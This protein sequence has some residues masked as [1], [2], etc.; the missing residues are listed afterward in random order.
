MTLTAYDRQVYAEHLERFLPDVIVDAHTHIWQPGTLREEAQDNRAC[1]SWPLMVAP[2]CTIE[3]LMEAYA[4][5][6]PGKKVYPAL[7]GYPTAV[8]EKTNAY[9]LA[10]AKR[11]HL[12]ALFCTSYQT[13]PEAIR[14]ALTED[15]FCGIKPYQNNS[16]PYIPENEIRIYDF[17][18]P[19]HLEVMNELKGVVML[20]ISRPGRLKDPVNLAQLLEIEEHYP[21]I[22]LIVAHIG[23]AYACEDLGN[24]FDLLRHTKNMVFD[25][26]ANTLDAAMQACLEAVGPRRL[27]FGSDM[28]IT[29]MRMRRTVENGVYYNIVPRG[30]YGDVSADRHMRETDEETLTTFMYEEL[31]AFK[32]CAERLG[33][34]R[35]EIKDIL[36]R[37]AAH[38]YGMSSLT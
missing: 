20:H 36:C 29:S 13:P 16:A 18:P 15:G 10:S 30:L 22:K 9:A 34:G 6:F 27:L 7:M 32:R 1:V 37:N 26:S 8:L 31:L 28:P 4:V 23:R 17:L 2:Y 25:F 21:A 33:L 12:P 14:R 5:L 35:E 24:A 11:Q 3:Q 38:I 19:S